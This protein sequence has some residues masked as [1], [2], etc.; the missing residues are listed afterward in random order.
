MKFQSGRIYGPLLGVAL[1]VGG[2]LALYAE[3]PQATAL[4][5]DYDRDADGKLDRDELH[6]ALRSLFPTDPQFVR[7]TRDQRKVPQSLETS[8]VAFQA[9]DGD[10]QVDLIGAVHVAD[11]EYYQ[12]L[13]EQFRKYD[14]VLYEL[15]APEGTRIPSGGSKSQHPVG[16]MQ[17]GIKTL[18]ELSFQLNHIDYTA[19]IWS[20]PTCRP[21]SSPRVWKIAAR[22]SSNFYF[23]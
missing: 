10:L 22:V 15:V 1:V 4:I 17:E 19:P 7:I 18:L 9:A 14:A 6:R 20:T 2:G 23:G 13:N 21:M 8:I 11:R 16:R 12:K 3:H 5:R